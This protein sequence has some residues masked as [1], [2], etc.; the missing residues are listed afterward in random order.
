LQ[1]T[2]GPYN[3]VIRIVSTGHRSL[4]VYPDKRTFTVFA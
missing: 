4:P 3:R 1:R 2:A